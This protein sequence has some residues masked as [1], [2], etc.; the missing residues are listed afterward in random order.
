M[1]EDRDGSGLSA[2][3]VDGIEE[4]EIPPERPEIEFKADAIHEVVSQAENALITAGTPIFQRGPSL[5]MPISLEVS[6]AHGLKT[7]SPSLKTVDVAVLRDHLARVV[8]FKKYHDRRK[9]LVAMTPPAELAA[10]LLSRAGEWR[11][12]PIVGVITT[13]TMRADGSILLQ[14]GYDPATGLYYIIGGNDAL[15]SLTIPERPTREDALAYIALFQDLLAEFPFKSDTDRSVALSAILCTVI[16]GA[17]PVVP[18]HAFSAPEAG[19][20]KSFLCDVVAAFANGNYC[21]VIAAGKDDIETD[22]RLDGL[23]LQGLPLISIDNVVGPLGSA[24]LCQCIERPLVQVRPLGSSNLVEIESRA[25]FLATGNNFRVRSDA[26]RRT[27]RGEMDAN[28]ERPETRSFRIDPFDV[29]LAD[30]AAYIAGAL[31]IIRAYQVSGEQVDLEPFQSYRE[32]SKFVREPLVWLG[33]EDPAKSTAEVRADDPERASF[34]ALVAAWHAAFGDDEVTVAMAIE[35][36]TSRESDSI[37]RAGHPDDD[38]VTRP[39]ELVSIKALRDA[40]LAVAG[41]RG[42]IDPVKM[43]TWM[44]DHKERHHAGYH[45]VAGGMSRSDGVRRWKV[46]GPDRREREAPITDTEHMENRAGLAA[47]RRRLRVVE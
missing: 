29:V 30:R 4:V 46:V 42:V 3:G 47:A 2:E 33:C 11:F 17:A 31:T 25:M 41:F 37:L 26:V 1:S 21:P 45:L 12:R 15:R 9:R 34:L 10:L 23:L 35:A 39:T 38:S 20:G 14:E 16:R 5:V 44:R 27:V 28:M 40:M 36:V 7:R 8:V 18:L 32:Y 13:P 43:G 22:K 24:T 6:A 19:T